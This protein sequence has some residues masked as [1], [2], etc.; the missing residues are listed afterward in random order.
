MLSAAGRMLED[1][2]GYIRIYRFNGV[3]EPQFA[4]AYEELQQQDMRALIIDLRENRGGLVDA[5]CDT[6]GHI[7]PE[8]VI[9]YEVDRNGKERKRECSGETPIGIPLVLLV[10]ENT[11]SASEMF[12]GA[13]QDYGIGKVAGTSTYGKG[14]EQNSYQLSDGSVVKITTT[15]YYTPA[16][17]DIN[18]VG[19]EP[20]VWVE[21]SSESDTQ[22]EEAIRILKEAA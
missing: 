1:D 21:A 19:I 18:E 10:N 13:V 7:L 4:K 5:C 16:M 17:R 22:L 15:R 6:L 12:T 9:V 2:I 14:V 8:G 20:D 11:A 3:T